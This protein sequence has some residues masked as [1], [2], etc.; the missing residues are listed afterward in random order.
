[1]GFEGR[2]DI[3]LQLP[4]GQVFEPLAD[5][6]QPRV[7]IGVFSSP[8]LGEIT[9]PDCVEHALHLAIEFDLAKALQAR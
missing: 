2:Q 9:A 8:L 5:R 4:E 7:S 3:L 6:V 1:M